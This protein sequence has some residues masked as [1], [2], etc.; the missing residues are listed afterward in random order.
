MIPAPGVPGVSPGRLNFG[1]LLLSQFEPLRKP[2]VWPQDAKD[3]NAA[4]HGD[5]SALEAAARPFRAAAGY[6]GAT[7]SSAISCADAPAR[8]GIR[9]WPKVI[10][11]LNRVDRLQGR[12]TGWWWSAPC[13]SWPVRGQDNYRGPWGA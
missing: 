9:S 6:A 12:S 1:D 2:A 4:I 10:G 7:T 8:R 3:L 5:G 11:R 13:A